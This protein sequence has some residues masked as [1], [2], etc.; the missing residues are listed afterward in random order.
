MTGTHAQ[1]ISA[2]SAADAGPDGEALLSAGSVRELRRLLLGGGPRRTTCV[3]AVLLLRAHHPTAP[4]ALDTVRLLL[5]DRRW[6]RLT[7][8]LVQEIV[9]TGLLSDDELDALALE[10]LDG[11]F[12]HY[13]LDDRLLGEEVVIVLPGPAGEEQGTDDEP[14][15]EVAGDAGGERSARRRIRPPLRRWGVA[16]AVARSLASAE[17]LLEL[18][19]DLPARDAAEAIRGMVDELDSLPPQIAAPLLER[20]LT[21]PARSVRTTALQHLVARGELARAR[22]LAAADHDATVR[23]A[24]ADREEQTSLF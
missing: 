13:R 10:L 2:E 9:G 20:T 5:T 15:D 23:A 22:A 16:R 18:T 1:A 7:V 21:W 14:E 24:F 3:D 6:D 4:G 12:L 17:E 19:D 11:E 8:R